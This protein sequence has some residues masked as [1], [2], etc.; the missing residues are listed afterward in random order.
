MQAQIMVSSIYEKKNCSNEPVVKVPRRNPF[1]WGKDPNLA[2]AK[3]QIGS[4][5]HSINYIIQ[6]YSAHLKHM[7]ANIRLT[8]GKLRM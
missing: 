7:Q 3:K 2:K 1:V 8:V 6:T 5:Q 4:S